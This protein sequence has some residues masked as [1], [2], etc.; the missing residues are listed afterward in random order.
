[1]SEPTSDSTDY[2]HVANRNNPLL[3]RGPRRALAFDEKT[4]QPKYCICHKCG[5]RTVAKVGVICSTIPCMKCG[6][7]M[8]DQ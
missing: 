2:A 3:G 1:M 7:K 4:Q 8:S 5:T 6:E